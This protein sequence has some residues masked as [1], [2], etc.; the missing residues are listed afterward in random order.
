MAGETDSGRALRVTQEIQ[1]REA[2]RVFVLA[3]APASSSHQTFSVK[4]NSGA[5]SLGAESNEKKDDA[6]S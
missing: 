1:G 2:M 5:A 3:K 6:V 4:G